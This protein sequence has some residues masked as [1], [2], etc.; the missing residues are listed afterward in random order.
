MTEKKHYKTIDY[1]RAISAL[2]VVLYHYTSRYNENQYI[3]E[4]GYT[5][6]WMF[7]VP[8]GGAAVSTF[9]LLSGFLMGKYISSCNKNVI[10][11]L[12]KR[13]VR[14][15]PTF[16]V[17]LT[18]T[19][20]ALLF[21]PGWEFNVYTFVVNLT[22]LPSNFGFPYIDGA[23]W[24]MACEVKFVFI[25]TVILFFKEFWIRIFF[26]WV[27]VAFSILNSFFIE[28]SDILFKIIRTFFIPDWLHVF[29]SGICIWFITKN[30]YKFNC[31]YGLL[32]LSLVNQLLW[33]LSIAH[34]IFLVVS[35]TILLLM[36]KLEKFESSNKFYL[37]F[38]YIARIS[39]PLYLIHQ[40]VGFT[41]ICFLQKEDLNS[42]YWIIIPITVSLTLAS[43]VHRFIEK[44]TETIVSNIKINHKI[45]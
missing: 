32:I 20:I 25:L 14:F 12:T 5:T 9:F 17:C 40:M 2:L 4:S 3:I 33:Q 27:L 39:Y 10:S 45:N 26:L 1:I 11:F 21:L 8:W 35:V 18:L 19:T 23:Y 15:Y 36:P 31:W 24:T 29:I 6:H 28:N 37:I 13:L 42:E 43:I 16:W 44:P 7:S 38:R 41:I 22:M 30:N 34:S